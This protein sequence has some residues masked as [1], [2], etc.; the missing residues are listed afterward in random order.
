MVLPIPVRADAREDAVRFVD[1][2]HLPAFFDRLDAAV[3]PFSRDLGAPGAMTFGGP[4]RAPPL[5]VHTVGQFE[6]SF[7]PTKY[8]FGRLDP[9]FR[10][11]ESVIDALGDRS[12][13][14]FVVVKLAKTRDLTRVHPV[15]FRFPSRDP[16]RVFFPTVHVH[17]G[18]VHPAADFDHALYSTD[19]A[20]AA[21]FGGFDVKDGA[22]VP[23]RAEPPRALAFDRDLHW[24]SGE[25]TEA[26]SDRAEA[27]LVDR[28]ERVFRR[29]V[30]G[31]RAND[32]AWIDRG[33]APDDGEVTRALE[34]AAQAGEAPLSVMSALHTVR[35]RRFSAFQSLRYGFGGPP[36]VEVAAI[37]PAERGG[38]LVFWV[39]AR[40]AN[41]RGP[42]DLAG[43]RSLLCGLAPRGQVPEVSEFAVVPLDSKTAVDLWIASGAKVTDDDASWLRENAG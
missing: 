7:V 6:A 10:L 37:V 41:L 20:R 43:A 23:A 4:Y 9:R 16:G 2:S 25:L 21:V 19:G 35:N 3:A 30:A 18:E 8:D 15:A 29:D 32:D 22:A 14:G 24:M 11:S 5:V 1:L 28:G 17:D 38:G 39:H 27:A 40:K 34:R 42:S 13:Y 33:F 12:G 31:R 26:V 36:E